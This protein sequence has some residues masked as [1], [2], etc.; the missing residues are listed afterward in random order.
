MADEDTVDTEALQAQIDLSMSYMH[1]L[2]SSWIKPSAKSV[3]SNDKTFE[4]ELQ[5]SL[6][7]PPRLGVGASI[8]DANA[9]NTREA[10]RLK[11]QLTGKRK[12]DTNDDPVLPLKH[13]QLSNDD[14][15]E[16]SRSG[17]IKKKV[18]SDPFSGK[19]K[20][21][22]L[23]TPLQSNT[24]EIRPASEKSEA[25]PSSEIQTSGAPDVGNTKD[26]ISSKETIHEAVKTQ[27]SEVQVDAHNS[28]V[29]TPATSSKRVQLNS[30]LP[31]LNLEGPVANQTSDD[32]ENHD[33]QS[34]T[35]SKKKRK[36]RKKKKSMQD[37]AM[38][39]SPSAEK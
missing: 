1:E 29:D 24:I 8:P 20:R 9:S 25:A 30:N 3:K 37:Q 36:R 39:V 27:H 5:E 19:D 33:T 21:K 35:P 28:Q 38:P 6:R 12:R 7:R 32:D 34:H 26:R 17:A 16:E 18:A 4:A 22:A 23:P 15:E 14:D 31:L 13:H 2:A 10:A 11:G